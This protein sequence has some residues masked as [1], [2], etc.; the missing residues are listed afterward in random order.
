MRSEKDQIES[1]T[2]LAVPDPKHVSGEEHNY[3]GQVVRPEG[4]WYQ[5]GIPRYEEGNKLEGL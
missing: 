5:T 1:P 2:M 4:L 3:I